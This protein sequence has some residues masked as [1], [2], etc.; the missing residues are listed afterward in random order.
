MEVNWSIMDNEPLYFFIVFYF[1]FERS[2]SG[3]KIGMI[4]VMAVTEQ[5]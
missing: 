3:E 2:V 4:M 5:I 1:L